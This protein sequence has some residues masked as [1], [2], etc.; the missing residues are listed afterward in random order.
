MIRVIREEIRKGH[1]PKEME[2]L[3]VKLPAALT[4][5]LEE[6]QKSGSG[7]VDSQEHPDKKPE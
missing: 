7:K 5:K 6:S 1:F 4:T 3:R 2:I